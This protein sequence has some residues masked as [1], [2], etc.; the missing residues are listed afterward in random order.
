MAFEE[1]L[2]L[3]VH[4]QVHFKNFND[5]LPEVKYTINLLACKLSSL[6]PECSR[7]PGS[8]AEFNYAF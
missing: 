1:K 4:L 7:H 8:G 5:V 6:G 3:Q 2:I